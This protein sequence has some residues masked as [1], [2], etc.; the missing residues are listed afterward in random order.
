L[1]HRACN[2]CSRDRW[3]LPPCSNGGEVPWAFI[4]VTS[5]MTRS[6]GY[7]VCHCNNRRQSNNRL[8]VKR[9]EELWMST[10]VPRIRAGHNTPE[11]SQ[12]C[13]GRCRLSRFASQRMFRNTVLSR[14]GSGFV[15]AGS[16]SLSTRGSKAPTHKLKHGGALI[17]C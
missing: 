2:G 16:T 11:Q 8:V 5:G 15:G 4:S 9:K 13:R 10:R 7:R 12:H 3:P 1:L 14:V 17:I 6:F